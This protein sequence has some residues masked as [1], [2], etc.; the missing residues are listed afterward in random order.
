MELKAFVKETLINIIQG[1]KEAQHEAHAA[2]GKVNPAI[3][4]MME[5]GSGS[6]VLGWAKGGGSSPMFLVQFDVAVVAEEGKE[7]KGG[8][9]VV[10]GVFALGSQG[11][12]QQNASN[13]SRIQF[14]VPVLLPSD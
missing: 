14:S 9:G 10:A 7:T 2:G 13:V 6:A 4:K 12:S 11:K 8:I 1:V 5:N 3:D